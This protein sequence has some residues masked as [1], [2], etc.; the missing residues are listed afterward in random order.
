[1]GIEP[2]MFSSEPVSSLPQLFSFARVR[3]CSYWR[4]NLVQ[5]ND[6]LYM[7]Q[8]K[9]YI[10]YGG[11]CKTFQTLLGRLIRSWHT[12]VRSFV[13][14]IITILRNFVTYFL[15]V[16]PDRS[17]VLCSGIHYICRRQTGRYNERAHDQLPSLSSSGGKTTPLCSRRSSRRFQVLG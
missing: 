13:N 5:R 16:T 8:R 9:V 11:C 1:V 4:Y 3:A 7:Q 2:W 10:R 12:Y 15:C 17:A 6:I 14:D